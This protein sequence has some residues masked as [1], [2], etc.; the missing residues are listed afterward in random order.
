MK[1][2]QY[3]IAISTFEKIRAAFP[4][5]TMNLDLHHKHVDLAMD[6]PTQQGLSGAA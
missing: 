1:T 3:G 5:L 4:A 2:D 6:I